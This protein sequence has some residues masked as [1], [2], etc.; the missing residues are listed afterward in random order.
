MIKLE[1]L[2]KEL[3]DKMGIPLND[4][5]LVKLDDLTEGPFDTHT[6]KNYVQENAND[7]QEY[8]VK[9]LDHYEWEPL[10]NLATFRVEGVEAIDTKEVQ[11][12]VLH[13]GQKVQLTHKQLESKIRHDELSLT[14]EISIDDGVTWIKINE[15]DFFQK[16]FAKDFTLPEKPKEDSF[17]KAKLI[18]DEKVLSL[19]EEDDDDQVLISIAQQERM[20]D[21]SSFKPEQFQH[22]NS[23]ATIKWIGSFAVSFAIILVATPFIMFSGQETRVSKTEDSEINSKPFDQRPNSR[24][25]ASVKPFQ[26]QFTKQVFHQNNYQQ[27]FNSQQQ[28]FE[29]QYDQRDFQPETMIEHEA[30]PLNE[31]SIVSQNNDGQSLDS[32]MGGE[33]QS[34]DAN[35]EQPI[36]EDAAEL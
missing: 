36:V 34:S 20:I 33:V 17:L 9:R 30:A 7:L 8:E 6:L 32:A 2:S 24:I 15:L 4:L 10:L 23:Q 14:N 29:P 18:V 16:K 12:F 1:A 11:Y 5:W 19:P 27:Q 25:P 31:P 28:H 35:L 13:Q 26:P 22:D 21:V 3:I